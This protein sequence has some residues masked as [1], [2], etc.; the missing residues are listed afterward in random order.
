MF[1]KKDSKHVL[2]NI[3]YCAS[4]AKFLPFSLSSGFLHDIIMIKLYAQ[5]FTQFDDME[6]WTLTLK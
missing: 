3:I 1:L 6:K 5:N 4:I 2:H